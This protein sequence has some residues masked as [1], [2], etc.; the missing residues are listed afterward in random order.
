M[1]SFT[2]IPA[3]P[4]RLSGT[5]FD[6]GLS[7]A[8]QSGATRHDLEEAVYSRIE[9]ARAAGLLD[10][11]AMQY[12]ALQ[13][14]FL[15]LHDPDTMNELSGIANGFR[16]PVEDLFIHQ[17]I[18]ILRDL[19]IAPVAFVEG[20][21]CSTWATCRSAE[22]PI[23]VKNR[24]FSGT[25]LGIQRVFFH[26][27]P[28]ILTGGMIC[29]GSAGSPGAYSSGMNGAGLAVVDNHVSA[30]IHD[31]GWL[32]YFLMTRI[33]ATC[34]TVEEAVSFVIEKAHAGGG[35]MILADRLGNTAA[36][37]LGTDRVGVERGPVSWRTN[38]FTTETMRDQNLS[39][40][41][42]RIDNNS[43]ARFAFLSS[44]LPGREWSAADAASLMATHEEDGPGF[45]PLCQ[46][47]ERNQSTTISSAIFNCKDKRLYF[48]EGNPCHGQWQSYEIPL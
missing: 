34:T 44:T 22:G 7:H 39:H 36:I 48:L 25:H 5:P 30:R 6:R 11:E 1:G 2:P 45:G 42:D 35:N 27:G 15:K 24:D 26:E 8:A 17:H 13:Q 4:L 12:L 21:G 31:I 19:K 46:H 41:G 18:T 47:G 16:L 37:E 40:G 32:R 23:T 3:S 38:H 29:V 10:T 14:A 33:L 9:Q 28:D 20:D 43:R